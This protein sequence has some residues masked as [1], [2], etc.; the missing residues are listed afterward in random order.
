MIVRD[1]SLD[2][3]RLALHST[4]WDYDTPDDETV[5]LQFDAWQLFVETDGDVLTAVAVLERSLPGA[6][7]D[8]VDDVIDAWNRDRYWPTCRRTEPDVLG[9]FD[10]IAEVSG[11]YP[12]GVTQQQALTQIQA[13]IASSGQFFSHLRDVLGTKG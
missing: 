5:V 2:L 7:M 13:A 1:L 4:G 8:E 12:S 11:Y 6:V 3:C 10:V 9:F